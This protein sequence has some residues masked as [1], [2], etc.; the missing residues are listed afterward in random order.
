[1]EIIVIFS[2]LLI[3]SFILTGLLI[4]KSRYSAHQ[5]RKEAALKAEQKKKDELIVTL[6]KI[7]EVR[8]KTIE[9]YEHVN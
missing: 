9:K 4:L 3:P 6:E 2:S 1:M 5:R 8:G 7:I